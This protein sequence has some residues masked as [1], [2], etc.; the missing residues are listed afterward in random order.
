M[1]DGVTYGAFVDGSYSKEGAVDKGAPK[2]TLV[3]SNININAD[4]GIGLHIRNGGMAAIEGDSTIN[5]QLIKNKQIGVLLSGNVSES[6]LEYK[7]T[8]QLL[9]KRQ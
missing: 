9:V 1:G 6:N 4:K 3:D 7:S 5:S 8:E 2:F